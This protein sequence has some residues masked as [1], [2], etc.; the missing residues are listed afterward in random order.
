MSWLSLICFLP[1]IPA[2]IVSILS[3]RASS[4]IIAQASKTSTGISSDKILQEFLNA[5]KIDSV[6]VVKSSDYLQNE[7]DERDGKIY[8]SPDT[9]GSVDAASIAL[10]LFA[11]AQAEL[12][13]DQVFSATSVKKT[14]RVET[15]LFWTAFCFLSF[16]I[17]TGSI[18]ISAIGYV[19]GG[20][21]AGLRAKRRALFK[22]I[23]DVACDY[24]DQS[25]A[26]NDADKT[27]VKRVLEAERR[28]R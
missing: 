22:K 1:L 20:S 14:Q 17:M 13:R 19:V 8:L 11:G 24:I 16:G 7:Y 25:D 23:D 4:K 21:V 18:L 26:L 3:Q 27:L 28:A 6:K 12:S 15:I 10:A 9:L 5:K 2:F